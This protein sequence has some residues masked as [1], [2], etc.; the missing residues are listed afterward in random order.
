[1]NLQELFIELLKKE[2]I[3]PNDC[4]ILDFIQ[5]YL[6]DFTPIRIDKEN[7]KNLFIYKKFGDGPHLCFAGHIDVVPP[8]DGWDTPPFEPTFKDGKVF[9]RGTQDMKSGVAAFV[10]A[11]KN[12]KDFKGTLSLLLTSDEEGEAKYGTIEVLKY[13]EKK[14]FLP[15]FAV[16]AEPTCENVFGDA[17]KVGRRGSI[18]FVLEIFG[19]QGHA[20][21]PENCINPIEQLGKIL[22]KIAG[23]NLDNGDENFAPSKI[24]VTD[25]RGGLEATNVTPSSVKVMFNVRNTTKTSQEDI[26]AYIK[27]LCKDLKYELKMSQGAFPFLTCVDSKIVKSIKESIGSVCSVE[28][29]YST[30]GG[31]SDARFITQYGVD[32][33]EFGVRNDSMHSVNEYTYMADVEKLRDCFSHLINNF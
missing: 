27:S 9:A 19:T 31:T 29:K 8:G 17:I 6:S 1:M 20:A 16:V 22:D 33:V 28:A 26:I 15:D 7:V 21:Y 24:V 14:N 11:V 25:I 12:A 4:G 13:L 32:V 3:T 18:N 30:A 23:F 5:E 2:S 10:D